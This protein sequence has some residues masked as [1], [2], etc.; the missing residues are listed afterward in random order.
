MVAAVAAALTL[1]LPATASAR[2][3]CLGVTAACP[4]GATAVSSLNAAAQDMQANPSG[5]N[6]VFIA[7]GAWAGGVVFTRT[8]E[9]IG[10]GRDATTIT[11]PPAGSGATTSTPIVLLSSSSVVRDLRVRMSGSSSVGIDL[12]P[13]GNLQRVAVAAD[14]PVDTTVGVKLDGTRATLDEVDVDLAN[15]RAFSL[16]RGTATITGSRLRGGVDGI[17]VAPSTGNSVTVARSVITGADALVLHG[18]TASLESSVLDARGGDGLTMSITPSFSSPTTATLRGVSIFG[19]GGTGYGIDQHVVPSYRTVL[20]AQDVL[21]GAGFVRPIRVQNDSTSTAAAVTGQLS[22]FAVPS[23]FA[24]GPAS[25]GL[26]TWLEFAGKDVTGF[27]FSSRYFTPQAAVR[28]AAAGDFRPR[29]DTGIVDRGGIAALPAAVDLLG[30]ARAVDGDGN[31]S[32]LRDI[33]AVEY[34]PQGPAVTASAAPGTLI[35]GAEATFTAAVTDDPG[36]TA[37]IVWTF[38]DGTTAS[39][40]TVRKAFAS[41]GEHTATVTA[42]DTTGQKGVA[43]RTVSV[44]TPLPSIPVYETFRDERR[45]PVPTVAQ[46]ARLRTQLGKF[47]TLRVHKRAVRVPVRCDAACKGAVT[48]RTA[49]GRKV[50]LAR[51]TFR[52][53]RAGTRTAKVRLTRSAMKRLKKARRLPVAVVVTAAGAARVQRSATLAR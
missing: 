12:N 17:D 25:G 16:Y 5:S 34:V 20:D 18:G 13:G 37:S 6:R 32:A 35:P 4:D 7:S 27:S 31:G 28:D 48:V 11:T 2:D 40:A 23:A 26:E 44:L 47:K 30:G 46:Q 42:T 29:I 9:I 52:L 8:V 24:G 51:A 33:G 1:A 38:D 49:K 14:S 43:T 15:G 41:P 45:P 50:V 53:A 10:A 19:S 21:F 36:D 22:N 3:Y 39:G